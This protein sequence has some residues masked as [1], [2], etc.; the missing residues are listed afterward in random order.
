MKA[1]GWGRSWER[2]QP[3][4]SAPAAG[5]NGGRGDSQVKP[6]E[7]THPRLQEDGRLACFEGLGEG[8]VVEVG[9]TLD[10]I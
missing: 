5:R 1:L 4:A 3:A 8:V 6:V 2:E 10:G 7:A 9:G